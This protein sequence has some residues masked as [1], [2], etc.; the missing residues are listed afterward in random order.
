LFFKK[1]KSKLAAEKGISVKNKQKV[2][3]RR[4]EPEHRRNLY[5]PPGLRLVEP[6][7]SESHYRKSFR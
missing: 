4:I 3:V 2:A 5:R 6:Y 1:G 7:A